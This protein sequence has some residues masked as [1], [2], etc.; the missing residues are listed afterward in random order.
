M[1]FE[2]CFCEKQS[3]SGV[4]ICFLTKLT[5]FKLRLNG[6]SRPSSTAGDF[7]PDSHDVGH[8]VEYHLGSFG[9]LGDF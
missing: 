8:D 4:F 9:D 3:Q 1:L 7:L 5:N 6:E 2:H